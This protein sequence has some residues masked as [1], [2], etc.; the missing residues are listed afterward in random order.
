MANKVVELL[1][2]FKTSGAKDLDKIAKS[3]KKLGATR[4]DIERA[5]GAY[6]DLNGRLRDARGQ[7]I[8]ADSAAGKLAR[9]MLDQ[10]KAGKKAGAGVDKYSK[11]ARTARFSTD[12]LS[13]GVGK[14]RGHMTGLVAAGASVV[15]TFATLKGISDRAEE[16]KQMANA[17]ERL[18]I[19]MED[20][21]AAEGAASK[22]AGLNWENLA[23]GLDDLN[24]RIVDFAKNGAGEAADLFAQFEELD[25][26]ELMNMNGLDQ[27][28][29]VVTAM[30]GLSKQER[31]Q[32]LDQLGSDNLRDLT[33]V[34]D[35]ANSKFFQMT[36]EIKASGQALDDLDVAKITAMNED[37]NEVNRNFRIM[38]DEAIS[39]LAPFIE[40]MAERMSKAGDEAGDAAKNTHTWSIA[41]ATLSDMVTSVYNFLHLSVASL[42]SLGGKMAELATSDFFSVIQSV[43]E[44]SDGV[45]KKAKGF[46]GLDAEAETVAGK[47]AGFFK[48]AGEGVDEFNRRASRNFKEKWEKFADGNSA[49]M[50]VKAKISGLQ[51]SAKKEGEKA[52]DTVKKELENQDVEITFTP[53]ASGIMATIEEMGDAMREAVRRNFEDE[54]IKALRHQH[55]VQMKNLRREEL[56]GKKSAAEVVK[57][58]AR[59]ERELN[60]KI[61]EAKLSTIAEEIEALKE[62]KREKIESFSPLHKEGSEAYAKTQKELKQIESDI[63]DLYIDRVG[64]IDSTRRKNE[65]ITL[66]AGNEL[67]GLSNQTTTDE[68]D[69]PDPEDKADREEEARDR[70]IEAEEMVADAKMELMKM[71]G[72][73]S[74]AELATLE[75]EFEETISRLEDAGQDTAIVEK[76]FGLKQANIEL[77]G[78]RQK[79]SQASDAYSY[80]EIGLGEYQRQIDTLAP[81]LDE[82]AG[83]TGND[84]AALETARQ[85]RAAQEEIQQ[86]HRDNAAEQERLDRQV[87]DVKLQLWKLTGREVE[88]SAEEIEGR[89]A[90]LLRQLGDD[91]EQADIVRKLIDVE[92]ANAEMDDLMDKLSEL[93]RQLKE[94]KIGRGEYN[95]RVDSIDGELIG[96][97]TRTG[98]DEN[99]RKA[100]EAI[101]KARGMTDIGKQIGEAFE[102]SFKTIGNAFSGFIAGTETAEEAFRKFAAGVVEQILNIIAQQLI[103]NAVQAAFGGGGNPIA[104]GFMG[105]VGAMHTGGT[106]GSYTTGKSVPMALFTGAMRYHDGGPILKPGEVPIIAQ[107]GEYM[108]DKYD[109]RNPRNGGSGYAQQPQSQQPVNIVNNISSQSIAQAM[110]TPDGGRVIE[111]YIRSNR[112][113]VKAM[114]G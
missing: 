63:N 1:L 21:S 4:K 67:I 88:A 47:V 60:D 8:K 80:G 84:S 111:N 93:Q 58:K 10:G 106:V 46:F 56:E 24:E 22:A 28:E 105:Q 79:L 55:D 41:A 50:D 99:M 36:D 15:A 38:K 17:A 51:E 6:V 70:R 5:K 66:G 101:E 59:L 54:A 98:S 34:L 39:E 112:S 74:Q 62:L 77:D 68:T 86:A 18:G 19:S 42:I 53:E 109:M 25:P 85:V 35:G 78:L 91:S 49:T 29:T 87:N 64:L 94:G 61:K 14:L 102:D 72:R 75:R 44:F 90:D 76:L 83:E 103:L 7:F 69:T 114:I 48:R 2:K 26:V 9:T 20:F 12:Q 95:D 52:S 16:M 89:Y 40:V 113:K 45:I 33:N 13:G 73:E 31:S 11:A 37:I 92:K 96:T 110:E 100:D 107:E 43:G 32:L 23:D 27:L 65:I 30:E 104:G 3:A 71:T 57:E 82:A 81:Q 108:L 97:A